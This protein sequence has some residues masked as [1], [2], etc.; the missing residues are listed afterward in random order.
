ML[1]RSPDPHSGRLGRGRNTVEGC[2]LSG[3]GPSEM[4]EAIAEGRPNRASAK[5]AYHVLDTIDQIM[6]SAETGAFEKVPSTCER[7]EAMPNS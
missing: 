2:Q 3:L 7:P 1:F 6:K 5:M 4:A